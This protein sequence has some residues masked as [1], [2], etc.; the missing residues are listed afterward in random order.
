MAASVRS[1]AVSVMW[2]PTAAG[3]STLPSGR[4]VGEG[5]LRRQLPPGPAPDLALCLSGRRPL[6]VPWEH[7]WIR[8]LD[9][10]IPPGR[11]R[12]CVG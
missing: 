5:A 11:R 7:H 2:D 6:P 9:F 12:R 10:S 3:V 4:F 1:V 8:W